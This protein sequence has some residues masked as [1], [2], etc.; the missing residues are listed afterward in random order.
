M[1]ATTSPNPSVPHLPHL[2]TIYHENGGI[3][4]QSE[5]FAN[6]AVGDEIEAHFGISIVNKKRWHTTQ[7]KE[8]D[9]ARI[10][11]RIDIYVKFIAP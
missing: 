2:L 1:N 9:P 10:G 8:S 11:D 4:L 6:P 5:T 7:I 3:L